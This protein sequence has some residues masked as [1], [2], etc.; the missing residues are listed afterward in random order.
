MNILIF[1]LILFCATC[2]SKAQD[3]ELKLDPKLTEVWEPEPRKVT[4]GNNNLAPSD[5]IVL[6]DGKDFSAWENKEGAKP[7]WK[8]VDNYF[9]VVPGKGIIKTKQGFGSVQLHIEWRSPVNDQDKGQ[10]RG[11]SG[12]FL[13][14]KYELQVLDSYNNQTYANG[15]AGSIYKQYIPLVNA[16]RPPGEWQNYDVIFTAPKFNKDGIL[17]S[18][19]RMTVL[20]NGILIQNNVV[21]KGNTVYNTLPKYEAHPEKLPLIL[22]DHSDEVSFR[23]IWLRELE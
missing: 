1:L 15:Q 18:P 11:N 17:I 19:A 7:E 8:I 20:H 3:K 10:G 6:F 12:I 16:C 22:Q 9:Q 5:A 13:M 14:G 23:N 21:L 4:P 2:T